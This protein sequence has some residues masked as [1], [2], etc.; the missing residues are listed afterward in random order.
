MWYYTC[1]LVCVEQCVILESIGIFLSGMNRL[2]LISCIIL[3]CVSF[4]MKTELHTEDEYVHYYWVSECTF[5]LYI[6]YI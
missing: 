1:T 3:E 4:N 2:S 5:L 6:F